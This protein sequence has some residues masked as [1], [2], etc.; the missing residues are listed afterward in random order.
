M[1]A[2]IDRVRLLE[3]MARVGLADPGDVRRFLMPRATNRILDPGVTV[4]TGARGSGKSSLAAWLVKGNF[5]DQMRR[6]TGHTLPDVPCVE[7]FS[8]RD[9]KHPDVLVLDPFVRSAD[10]DTLRNFWLGHLVL[11]F[12]ELMVSLG[13][14]PPTVD[15]SR[16]ESLT[17][18]VCE[19][20]AKFSVMS[21]HERGQLVG[22]IDEVERGARSTAVGRS[23]TFL[24][25]DL[26]TV[27]AFDP[28]LRAR[29]IRA[30]LAMWTTFSTRYKHFRAKIFLPSDL[31]DLRLFDTLD[32]S[33]LMAR[34]ERLE[35]DTASLY[36]LVLRHL[37][38]EGDDVRAWLSSFGVVFEDKGDDGWMPDEPS[39]EVTRRWLT[40]TLRA[41]VSAHG[42]RSHVDKWIANR[43]RD[44]RDRVA[45]RSMLGFF[46]ESARVALSRPPRATRNHLLAVDDAVE[47]VG[48]VGKQRVDEI[49]AVYAWVDRL[50]HLRGRAVPMARATLEALVKEDAPTA[51]RPTEPRD[52][53]AVT[54]EL[55]RLGMLREVG[56]R[57]LLDVPDLFA[58]HWGVVRRAPDDAA[59]AGAITVGPP[60]AG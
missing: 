22:Y 19:N 50:E 39:E 12:L 25:D 28:L 53:E 56:G 29:F 44:G 41:I 27:G 20:P 23:L 13:L 45:P 36:R 10:D 32:V 1:T 5:A 34:A 51:P 17:K 3:A 30:L 55:V 2:E 52:G 14:M 58:R 48:T 38:A 47:A 35:W 7:A 49:R 4:V 26:D 57:D 6:R 31:F 42:T 40:A 18:S 15:G 43:L 46:R 16:V 33:K 21:P 60:R 9:P 8:Q 37:G 54:T 24:Y 11:Q 59:P